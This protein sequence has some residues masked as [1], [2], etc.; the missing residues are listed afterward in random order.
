MSKH[1]RKK[2]IYYVVA[3]HSITGAFIVN[4]IYEDCIR[5]CGNVDA[6][7]KGFLRF[8][9]SDCFWKRF[10]KLNE[11]KLFIDELNPYF[12]RF[13]Q[14]EKSLQDFR[15]ALEHMKQNIIKD[16]FKN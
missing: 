11:A 7:K 4:V 14:M 6:G 5:F 10:E 8:E 3:H 13:K 9:K 15:M 1:I 2:Q 16:Y 12:E